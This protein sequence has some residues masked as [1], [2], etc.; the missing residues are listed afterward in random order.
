MKNTKI[1]ALLVA[2]AMVL[3]ILNYDFA[4]E[5]GNGKFWLFLGQVVVLVMSLFL[6][7]KKDDKK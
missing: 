6:L 1:T 2:V 3:G 5:V 7:L 4:N